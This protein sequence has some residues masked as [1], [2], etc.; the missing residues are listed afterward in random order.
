[1]LRFLSHY[2]CYQNNSHTLLVT[3]QTWVCTTLCAHDKM[4]IREIKKTKKN[5]TSLHVI[6][7]SLPVSF[8]SVLVPHK[9]EKPQIPPIKHVLYW[10][11]LSWALAVLNI[12][13]CSFSDCCGGVHQCFSFLGYHASHLSAFLQG[14]ARRQDSLN[15][16]T[17][18]PQLCRVDTKCPRSFKS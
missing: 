6:S 1:M 8:H 15:W 10:T 3:Q 5:K 14:R 16:S 9:A 7:P 13:C 4:Y 2:H 12:G 18:S 11:S 17:I